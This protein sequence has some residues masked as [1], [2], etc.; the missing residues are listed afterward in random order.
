[1]DANPVLDDRTIDFMLYEVADLESLF[2]QPFF[3][4]HSRETCDLFLNSCRK[5][6]REHMLPAYVEMDEQATAL[7]DGRVVVSERMKDLWPRMVELGLLTAA[8]PYEVEGSQLP[9]TV[10]SAALAYLYGANVGAA[11]F[12]GLSFAAA[13]LIESFGDDSLKR[14]FMDRM[15]AGEWTGTMALTEPQAGSSLADVKTSATPLDNGRYAIKGAKIFISGGDQNFTDNVVNMTLA[16]IEGAPAGTKGISLFAVPRLRP[17]GDELVDND[18]ATAGVVHK[19][20]WRALPSIIQSYGERDDCQGWLVGKPHQGLRYM[21]QMMNE[22]RIGVGLSGAATASVGYLEA[23]DYAKTRPQG[24]PLSA[25]SAGDPVAIIEHADVRRMLLRQKAIAEGALALVFMTARYVDLAEHS[26]DEAEQKRAQ[27]LT[28]LLTPITKT[29]P[30]EFGFEANALA[31]QVLGGYGYSTEYRPQAWMRDQKLNSIHEGTT[32]IQGLDLLGR[33][34]M[35]TGGAS[36]ALLAEEVKRDVARAH[37]AGVDKARL[38]AMGAALERVA[39]CTGALGQRASQGPEVLMRHSS[40][41]LTMLS[42]AV[43]A[44]LWLRME[45]VAREGEQPADF[46]A[47]KCRASQYWFANEVPR[48]AL[49]AAR[50]EAG[51]DAYAQIRPSEL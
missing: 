1:M 9:F 44:W 11:G 26:E 40:D 14:L 31:V 35:R 23:L 28:D 13:H 42:I 10:Q 15:Y 36:L 27:Q 46:V 34:V 3:A 39:A 8:R 20:G 50:I 21:F 33:K 22:S 25:G 32:G 38:A 49:L 48:I 18:V 30:A 51:D 17:E 2:G 4:D 5:V 16:R 7:V 45:A 6:A 19:L 29:F 12:A 37:E 43:V 47:G 24:R 41:Y